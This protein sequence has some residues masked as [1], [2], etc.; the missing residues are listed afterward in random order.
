MVMEPKAYEWHNQDSRIT[1]PIEVG[2]TINTNAGGR[3]GHLILEP[4]AY[5]VTSKGNGDAFVSEERHTTLSA[6]GGLPGQ[7]YPCVAYGIDPG[8]ARD[9]GSLF[10]E[11]QSKTITN[12][13]CPGHHNGVVVA[14]P[15]ISVTA[16]G[17]TQVQEENA[18]TLMARAYKDPTC[19]TAYDESTRKYIV[20]RLT[21]TECARLQGFADR[22]GDIDHKT[23][24][25]DEE[26]K[27]WC[28]VYLT[29]Q[30]ID[31]TVIYNENGEPYFKTTKKPYKDKARKQMLTWYNKL[32]S[33]GSEYKMWGNGIALPTALFIMQGIADALSWAEFL[34]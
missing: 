28:E 27:F 17:F 29:K 21:P 33:D 14:K 8:A 7:G 24:L 34:E 22:W 13:S 12:G 25:T 1:G 26:Y 10:I 16:G 19:I 31:G 30:V 23:F 18:P 20:R 2:C 4:K 11:E 6:G 15:T 3:E 5:G 32:H 9:V